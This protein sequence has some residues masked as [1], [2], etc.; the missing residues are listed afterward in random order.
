MSNFNRLQNRAQDA[1]NELC[2]LYGDHNAQFLMKVRGA[3]CP[4][5]ARLARE[6]GRSRAA[7][8]A[9]QEYRSLTSLRGGYLK[10]MTACHNDGQV[11]RLVENVGRGG[12]KLSPWEIDTAVAVVL[13]VIDAKG[14]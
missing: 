2:S 5:V 3:C 12:R 7:V 8:K 10:L 14:V 1:Y 6:F 9:V 11:R 4:V 13:A